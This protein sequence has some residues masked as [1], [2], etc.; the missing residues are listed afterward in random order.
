MISLEIYENCVPL[1]L[2]RLIC[3]FLGLCFR[4]SEV[5]LPTNTPSMPCIFISMEGLVYLAI[6]CGSSLEPASQQP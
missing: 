4:G 3:L 2:L 5:A 6:G 1:Q